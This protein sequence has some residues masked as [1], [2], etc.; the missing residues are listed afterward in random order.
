MQAA[1]WSHWVD[2][3]KDNDW[4]HRELRLGFDTRARIF[5]TVVLVF[6]SGEQLV[7]H[8]MIAR[9]QYWDLLLWDDP[10]AHQLARVAQ[11]DRHGRAPH[12]L[13]CGTSP[14]LMW[15]PAALPAG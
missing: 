14:D 12:S 9:K 7:I 5:K 11:R 3:L 6:E 1:D 4:P 2:F 10:P 15:S 13:G 8:A